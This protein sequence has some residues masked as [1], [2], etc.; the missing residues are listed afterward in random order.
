M[1]PNL[2]PLGKLASLDRIGNDWIE[3]DRSIK[4]ST[5]EF[6]E[7]S[8]AIEKIGND[9]GNS[10]ALKDAVQRIEK[11]LSVGRDLTTVID[12]A[13]YIRALGAVVLKLGRKA[14]LSQ[15]LLDHIDTIKEKPSVILLEDLRQHYLM[16]YDQLPYCYELER[17]I[18]SALKKRGQI[19]QL[20]S[21]IF[22]SEGAKWLADSC[23]EQDRDFDNAVN[24]LG[25]DK[26]QSGRFITVSQQIYFVEQL[27]SIPVNEPHPLLEEMQKESV[28]SAPYGERGL[29]GHEILKTM[30]SRAPKN[31]VHD[32]WRNVVMK[33]AGDPRISSS[34][35]RYQ[36]WWLHLDQSLINKVI[37]WLSGLDLRLFLEALENYSEGSGDADLLRMYPARKHFL[38]GLLDKELVTG[39]RLYLTDGFRRYLN[40]NY[41]PEHLPELYKVTT[42]NKSVLH[43]QLGS[44]HLIEGSHSCR[45]WI[46]RGLSDQAVVFDYSKKN[47][48]Y[49]A[50]T[51]GLANQMLDDYGQ[52][53]LVD[54][55]THYPELTWQK[56]AIDALKI[57]GIHI[58]S[59]DVL[60]EKDYLKYIRKYG[61]LE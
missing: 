5:E 60:T 10:D 49:S 53:L 30:I 15:K 7:L 21:V 27:K 37:G 23:I 38:Q 25:L 16:H 6:T 2:K 17:W 4:K 47:V 52:D 32:S 48:S 41:R 36:K 24:D 3:L 1:K 9:A 50:L 58:D 12:S 28:Y 45:L 56:K 44:A 18:L 59:K 22:S 46:Y 39:T 54:N 57:A 40:E 55:I 8:K 61:V 14:P 31:G 35:P 19:K 43:I 29:L 34:Q 20:S 42:N 26:Y 51:S 11:A 33:I 13:L